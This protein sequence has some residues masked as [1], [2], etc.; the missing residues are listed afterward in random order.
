MK[1][2]NILLVFALLYINLSAN[3]Q[4]YSS[5]YGKKINTPIVFLHGGPGY[6]SFT[7]EASTAERLADEGYYVIVYDQRGCGRSKHSEENK[8]NFEEAVSD[9]DEIYKKYGLN[10]AAILG[11]SWGGALGLMF[12]EKYPEKVDRLILISAPMDY[13]QTFVAM[14]NHARAVYTKD[15]KQTQLKYLDMLETFDKTSLQYANYCFMQ[16]MSSGQYSV[17]N[18]T[19]EAEGIKSE[20]KQ[21]PNSSL[22]TN[23]TQEPVLGLYENEHYTNLK[24]Y[25]RLSAVKA[26]LPILGIFGAEDGLFDTK[27]L[28]D[29][30]AVVG[31]GNFTLLENAS[32][33][34][35][36]DQQDEFINVLQ[37]YLN[38]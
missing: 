35:F 27:Q 17:D 6:N 4:L 13:Q 1:R 24:L 26:Q 11:H 25:D 28:N 33:S 23:M 15:N 36:I 31:E 8:Y 9:L 18:P 34:V 5:A 10:K 29:I 21:H 2:I 20:L 14:I 3:A 32:H 7:F 22:A 38:M 19:E 30:K 12:A 37:V 16:A